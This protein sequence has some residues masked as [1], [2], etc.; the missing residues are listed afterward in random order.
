MAH[1]VVCVCVCVCMKLNLFNGLC[2][3]SEA[4]DMMILRHR[5]NDWDW[6][7]ELQLVS[8]LWLCERWSVGYAS[9][10]L[11]TI[12]NYFSGKMSSWYSD[13]SFPHMSMSAFVVCWIFQKCSS[14]SAIVYII[15][16]SPSQIIF[17]CWNHK[18]LHISKWTHYHPEISM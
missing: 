14:K 10:I 6:I 16:V 15:D 12:L 4:D 1:S 9:T 5:Q 13:H 2:I 3:F 17:L 18:K 8:V 7:Q 11:Y